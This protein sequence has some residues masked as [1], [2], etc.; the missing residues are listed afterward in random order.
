[1]DVKDIDIVLVSTFKEL[2]GMPFLVLHPGFRGRVFMTL[3][4]MQIG[5]N[6]LLELVKL[7]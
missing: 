7:N 4:L 5:Q 3:P 1:M 6:L 2:A